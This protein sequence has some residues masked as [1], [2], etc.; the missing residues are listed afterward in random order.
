MASC[1]RVFT[2]KKHLLTNTSE[3]LLLT[4]SA[5]MFGVCTASQILSITHVIEVFSPGHEVNRGGNHDLKPLHSF[6]R[7][8]A[9]A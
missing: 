3:A 1:V 6:I 2:K 9:A 7:A 5:R 8:R 4:T